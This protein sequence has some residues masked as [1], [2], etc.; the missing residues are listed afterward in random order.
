MKHQAYLHPYRQHSIQ[1]RI[2][3][4]LA[5]KFY[6]S[7]HICDKMGK[8]AYKLGLPME[9]KIH[10]VFHVSLLKKFHVTLPLTIVIPPHI[11]D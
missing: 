11:Q 10:N 4:K 6:G 5:Y 7:F 1:A 2:N 3:Q 9:S 8:V